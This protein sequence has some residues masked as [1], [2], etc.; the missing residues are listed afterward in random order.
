VLF[1][2]EPSV[3]LEDVLDHLR[4]FSYQYAVVIEDRQSL[5][6]IGIVD[7]DEVEHAI[8]RE[9]LRRRKAKPISEAGASGCSPYTEEVVPC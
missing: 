7:V 6:P 8:N 5:R 3:P 1:F 4:R 2:V 9:I